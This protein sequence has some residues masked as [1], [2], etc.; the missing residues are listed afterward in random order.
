MQLRYRLLLAPAALLGAL[1]CYVMSFQ[2]GAGL[3]FACGA[4]LEIAAWNTAG[5]SRTRL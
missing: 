5:C 4:L 3:L 2:T 1:V